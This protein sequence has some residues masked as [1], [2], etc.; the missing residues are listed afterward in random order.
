MVTTFDFQFIQ[1]TDFTL[2]VNLVNDGEQADLN[3]YFFASQVKNLCLEEVV[4]E[5][6]TENNLIQID[7]NVVKLIFSNEDTQK[8]PVGNY[9]YDL[10]LISPDNKK[11]VILSGVITCLERITDVERV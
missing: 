6:T 4:L 1:G 8:I 2:E 3:D 7:E 9:K 11:N 10:L 5:L